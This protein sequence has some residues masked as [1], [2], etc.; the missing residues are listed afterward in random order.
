MQPEP[1]AKGDTDDRPGPS[2]T[3]TSTT[4]AKKLKDL[5]VCQNQQIILCVSGVNF[6]TSAQTL[7]GREPNSVLARMMRK[8]SPLQP[9]YT[10][11]ILTYYVNRSPEC[12]KYILDYLLNGEKCTLQEGLISLRKIFVEAGF[13]ELSELQSLLERKVLRFLRGEN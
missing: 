11:K 1:S 8:T 13:Y 5:A 3:V 6:Y 9:Y 10:D 2:T 7:L 4:A 12:F